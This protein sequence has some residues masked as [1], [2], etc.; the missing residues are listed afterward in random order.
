MA[1]RISL[2]MSDGK[3]H[4]SDCKGKRGRNLHAETIA[5]GVSPKV[6]R[7]AAPLPQPVPR[8]KLFGCN[9]NNFKKQM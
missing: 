9:I 7:H 4:T 1:S 3:L 5:P 6:L 8:P 2:F